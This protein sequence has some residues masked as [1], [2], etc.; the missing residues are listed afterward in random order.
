MIVNSFD[1]IS[2][3]EIDDVSYMIER[4]KPFKKPKKGFSE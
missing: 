1:I 2:S 3:E 4:M